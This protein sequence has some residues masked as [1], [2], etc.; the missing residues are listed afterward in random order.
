MDIHKNARSCP[1][2][3]ALLVERVRDHGW[4]VQAAAL[5]AGISRRRA[6]EWIR[7]D[8]MNEGL[9]DRSSR[10]RRC[11]A[12]TGR[13]RR[14][15]VVA[16]RQMRLTC[17]QIAQTVGLS[18]ATVAR[19]VARVGLSRLAAIDAPAPPR[20]YQWDNPGDLVHLDIKKLGRIVGGVGHRITGKRGRRR[21]AGWEFVHVC[22]D[23]ASRLAYAEV[24]CA[25][26]QH[27]VV[28]FLRR[29]IRWF[30]N[31]G[32]PIKRVMTDNGGG[33]ISRK[34]RAFCA[35]RGLRQIRIRPYTPRTN[36]KAERLIQTLLREWAYRFSYPSSARRM[37]MLTDY[38][39]F[40]NHHRAHSALGYNPP[41]SRLVGNNLLR[42]DN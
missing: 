1:A 29:A 38:L 32:I 39:H 19:I 35:A 9:K 7:R 6:S 40:Y 24:L 36:G 27:A 26:D 17:R 21:G 31:H 22:I 3:R 37:A 10:P 8:R 30:A 4:T 12:V 28:G 13:R 16:L 42:R 11:R 23:D 20:R 34:F 41:I 33:Y 2:S 5:A 25:Q 14:A 18:C 15:E